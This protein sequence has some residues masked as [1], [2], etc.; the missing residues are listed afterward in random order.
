MAV[1]PLDIDSC[2]SDF[3]AEVRAIGRCQNDGTNGRSREAVKNH[4]QASSIFPYSTENGLREGALQ[5][6]FDRAAHNFFLRYNGE[7]PVLSLRDFM[8]RFERAVVF[9]TL[10][11]THGSQKETAAVLK[12]KKQT[13]NWKVKRQH[14]LIAK[15]PM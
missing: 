9:E 4:Q 13:L 1:L 8:E 6:H 5:R 14:I 2:R 15:V 7:E 12:L 10:V 11:R 3:M